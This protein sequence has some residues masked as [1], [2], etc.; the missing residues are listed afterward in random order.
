M[1]KIKNYTNNDFKLILNWWVSQNEF[2][3]TEDMLPEESTFICEHNGIPLTA[4]TVYLTNSKEFCM[5]DNFIGN[6]KFPGAL[7]KEASG[8]I[9]SHAEKF[10]KELGYKSIM[11]LATENKLKNYYQG[12]GYIKRL[13]NIS[14]FNKELV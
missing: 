3:P 10:A 8:L 14:S 1:F 6:P 12:F 9:I 7:R 4:I 5:F 2:P 11:C 13:D